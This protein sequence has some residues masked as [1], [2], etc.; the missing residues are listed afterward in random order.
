MKSPPEGANSEPEDLQRVLTEDPLI[1]QILVDRYK[2]L[3]HI[4]SGEVGGTVTPRVTI[5][6]CIWRQLKWSLDNTG[7]QKKLLLLLLNI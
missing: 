5:P 7:T 6:T 4:A 1:G 2:I 3:E